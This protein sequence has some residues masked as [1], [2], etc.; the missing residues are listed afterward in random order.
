MGNIC[1]LTPETDDFSNQAAEEL[2]THLE[3]MSGEVWDIL[4]TDVTGSAIR[5]W[6]DSS[7]PDFSDRSSEALRLISD[8]EGIKIVGNH[9]PCL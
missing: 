6:V 4:T 5:I 9:I 3:Q 8:V 2:K 1:I 7:L